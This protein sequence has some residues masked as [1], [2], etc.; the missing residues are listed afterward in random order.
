LENSQKSKLVN[1]IENSLDDFFGEKDQTTPAT[2]PDTGS[3]LERLKSAVLSIDWEITDQCLS[4]LTG[5][6]D[7]LLPTYQKDP[8]THALLRMLRA[9]S[10]YIQQRKAQAHQDAIKRVMS[11]F[12]SIESLVNDK[13]M[14]QSDRKRL[15]A[16][17]ISAFK[18]LKEQIE[19]QRK[20]A[21]PIGATSGTEG[22]AG[23][24]ATMENG[25]FQTA[26]S[27]LESRFNARIEEMRGQIES[28]RKELDRLRQG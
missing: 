2:P 27:E 26:I 9:L 25:A 14:Q 3:P 5:E 1:D 24:A 23:A 4:D 15:V 28:L 17:E 8:E 6:T 11:V 20:S 7:A 10:R 12:A 22:A 21:V 19:S 18:K 13:Q 16:K